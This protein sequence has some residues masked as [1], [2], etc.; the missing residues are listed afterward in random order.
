MRLMQCSCPVWTGRETHSGGKQLSLSETLR[1]AHS[2]RSRRKEQGEAFLSCVYQFFSTSEENQ[3]MIQISVVYHDWG[4]FNR[5][6]LGS[7]VPAVK[8]FNWTNRSEA[9]TY[10]TE[11][12]GCAQGRWRS[13]W[14]HLELCFGI[15]GPVLET[16]RC[17]KIVR[18]GVDEEKGNRGCWDSTDL[19]SCGLHSI[20]S[21]F[22]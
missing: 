7:W 5:G 1:E 19:H 6:A 9:I 10:T 17:L 21:H 22:G 13:I 3:S 2:S 18:T 8:W 15:R 11:E 12:H 4:T 20:S 16:E 14:R